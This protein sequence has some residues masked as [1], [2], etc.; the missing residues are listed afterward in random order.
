MV[1][2][3]LSD[4][5]RIAHTKVFKRFTTDGLPTVFHFSSIKEDEAVLIG[6]ILLD[7]GS[8]N[9]KFDLKQGHCE[10]LKGAG[11]DYRRFHQ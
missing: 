4:G 8:G 2:Y 6:W 10:I 5:R 11:A 3:V 7:P 9:M 1:D